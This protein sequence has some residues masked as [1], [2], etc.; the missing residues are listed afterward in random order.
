M[1]RSTQ[2]LALENPAKR[3]LEYKPKHAELTWYNKET[4]ENVE[5]K[6]PFEFLPLDDLH[7]IGGYNKME[8]S[9]YVSNEVRDITKDE[10]I[11]RTFK[12]GEKY[13]G[14]YK[15]E[16]KIVMMPKGAKYGKSIYFAFKEDSQWQ[17][18]AIKLVGSSA[19]AWIEFTQQ[20]WKSSK[21]RPTNG[22]VI[23]TKGEVV[24]SEDMGDY[25][26]PAFEYKPASDEEDQAAIE[27]DKTLQTYLD[28]Y[29]KAPK[30]EAPDTSLHVDK[31]DDS[32][33]RATPEQIAEFDKL[34]QA[35]LKAQ[36]TTG[37]DDPEFASLMQQ[38]LEAD[39]IDIP[40][41]WK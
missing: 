32:D 36:P 41:E 21:K 26:P 22:K 11:V 13:R 10:L 2:A 12:G 34:K 39:G 23:M 33:T 31:I 40:E 14:L 37:D 18:G 28:A 4:S 24:H 5:V 7:T 38:G 1:S 25:Y 29:L 9:G 15:N 3:W 19:T 8:Q 30:E 17:I 16:Q 20:L 35:K 6:M 27:L